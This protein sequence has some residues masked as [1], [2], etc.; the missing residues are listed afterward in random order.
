METQPV[1]MKS[2]HVLVPIP[3]RKYSYHTSPISTVSTKDSPHRSVSEQE[4]TSGFSD[5]SS[6]LSAGKFRFQQNFNFP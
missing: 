1:A 5:A 2:P 3:L 6:V 4:Q